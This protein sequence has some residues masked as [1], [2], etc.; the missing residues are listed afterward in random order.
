MVAEFC[1]AVSGAGGWGA[2][3]VASWA[4]HIHR[5]YGWMYVLYFS[6]KPWL[7]PNQGGGEPWSPLARMGAAVTHVRLWVMVA[8]HGRM[9]M[10]GRRDG[11][12]GAVWEGKEEGLCVGRWGF[13][14]M[15]I[16]VWE[17]EKKRGILINIL[18]ERLIALMELHLV[19]PSLLFLLWCSLLFNFY[20]I[21]GVVD[22]LLLLLRKYK[23]VNFSLFKLNTW[24]RKEWP[25]LLNWIS[26]YKLFHRSRAIEI[27]LSVFDMKIYI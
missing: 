27:W 3:K 24:G 9:T 4:G 25:P 13:V 17:R 21:H 10:T 14:W 7:P 11:G 6:N 1:V 18:T 22:L 16:C 12:G 19:Y 20:V 2:S 5:T 23:S 15:Y 8:V 26:E